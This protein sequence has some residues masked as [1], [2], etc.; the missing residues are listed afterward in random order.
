MSGTTARATLIWNERTKL[1]ANAVDRASTVLGVGSLWPIWQLAEHRI[2]F[3][4]AS[5]YIFIFVAYLLHMTA[6]WVLKGLR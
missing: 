1:L 2:L 4:A 3:F 6:R 5:A